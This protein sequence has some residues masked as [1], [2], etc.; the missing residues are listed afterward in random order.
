MKVY[1]D[2][3]MLSRKEG[4]IIRVPNKIVICVFITIDWSLK[5]V[6]PYFL[7]ALHSYICITHCTRRTDLNR[8]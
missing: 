6:A 7:D 3:G 5:V 2:L 8:S 1:A 4:K